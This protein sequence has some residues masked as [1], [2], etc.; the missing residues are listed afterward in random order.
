MTHQIIKTITTNGIGVTVKIDFDN[1]QVSLVERVDNTFKPKQF[2]FH[3][4]GLDY[5]NGWFNILDAMQAAVIE[6]QQMLKKDKEEKEKVVEDK[7]I[8][9][10]KENV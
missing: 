7:I 2:I 6:A 9:V 5:M 8:S 4:R 1:N 3:K 10:L